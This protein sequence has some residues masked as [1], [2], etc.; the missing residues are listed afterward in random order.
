MATRDM[1]N[2]ET[3]ISEVVSRDGEED[4][5]VRGRRLSELIGQLSFAEM[6]F[7][8]LQGTPPS[9]RQARM[10]DALL[11]ASLE[12]GIAP[13]SMISRCFAS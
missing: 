10:L 13:P 8:V 11:V 3:G 12:H 7:L 9:A 2:W 4:V 6:M 5:I 1:S